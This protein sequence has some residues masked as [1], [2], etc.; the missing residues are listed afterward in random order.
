MQLET[1][2]RNAIAAAF[3]DRVDDDADP[4]YMQLE[5]SGNAEVATFVFQ[6][7]SFGAPAA[8]VITLLGVPI[9]DTNA[10]GGTVAKGCIYD[11]DDVKLTEAA[12]A[13]AAAPIIMS[14]LTVG[15]TETVTLTT[16]T[17]TVPPGTPNP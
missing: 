4:G 8:G 5:T 13:T 11:G 17:V 14:S 1:A 16:L 15:A 12:A 6:D 7:P 2:M 9:Q 3:R 10:T